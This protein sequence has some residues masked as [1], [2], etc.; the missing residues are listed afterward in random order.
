MARILA[1]A[2]RDGRCIAALRCSTGAVRLPGR[3]GAHVGVRASDGA[4]RVQRP[5]LG[6]GV[7][8]FANWRGGGFGG[9]SHAGV[10]TKIGSHNAIYITQHSQRN[11][12]DPLWSWEGKG[13]QSANPDVAVWIAAA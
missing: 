12:S 10:I 9:I 13:W 11:K 7:Q 3:S 4:V 6:R 2:V 8:I 1:L 5:S